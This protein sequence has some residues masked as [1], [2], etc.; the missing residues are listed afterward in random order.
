VGAVAAKYIGRRRPIVE[1]FIVLAADVPVGLIQYHED[2]ERTGGIELVLLEEHRR[3]GIGR[4]A[5]DAIVEF[6][7]EKL[8]WSSITVAPDDWNND[9]KTFWAA[10]GFETV[11]EVRDEAG[12][13]PYM[14]MR[15][16]PR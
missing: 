1:C 14:L 4:A 10:V 2:D 7:V 15:W 12:R 8:R 13:E 16:T 11:R 6:L 9:G 5:A 3:L